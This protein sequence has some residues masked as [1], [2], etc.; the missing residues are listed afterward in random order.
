M[1]LLV[2]IQ[3]FSP[4]T[5]HSHAPPPPLPTLAMKATMFEAVPPGHEDKSTMP[6]A[7]AGSRPAYL[8]HTQAQKEKDGEIDTETHIHRTPTSQTCTV[9]RIEASIPASHA[10]T[11]T[12]THTHARTHTRTRTHTHIHTRTRTRTHSDIGNGLQTRYRPQQQG[13]GLR[14]CIT[15]TL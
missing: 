1:C 7:A 4:H 8:H 6:M 9:N 12:H 2:F 10:C 5:P 15:Y 11:H 14:T 3:R 13:Q